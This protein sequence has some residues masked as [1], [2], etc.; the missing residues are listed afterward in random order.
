MPQLLTENERLELQIAAFK[1]EIAEKEE[2]LKTY[3][4]ETRRIEMETRK[5]EAETVEK[6]KVLKEYEEE[7]RK[8]EMFNM[9][10]NYGVKP[11]GGQKRQMDEV[12]T[13]EASSSEE[14]RCCGCR[15]CKG[16]WASSGE[17]ADEEND[18]D[19]DEITAASS[20]NK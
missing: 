14:Q 9:K 11:V 2:F 4:G 3:R 10:N 20:K 6:E 16:P 5:K 18:D 8:I 19:G 13:V 17:E 7:K 1:K 12:Q 15:S